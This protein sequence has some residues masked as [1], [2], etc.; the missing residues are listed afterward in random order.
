MIDMQQ[1]R[2]IR[3]VKISR[4]GIKEYKCPITI[5]DKNN[6][7]QG[8]IADINLYVSLEAEKRGI[9]MSRLIEVINTLRGKVTLNSVEEMLLEV[10][11]RLESK[12]S[13]IELSFP[14]FIEKKAP[15]SGLFGVVDYYCEIL[16]ES[17]EDDKSDITLTVHVPITSV[18]PCSKAISDNGA[19]NQRGTV[20]I[21]VKFKNEIFIEDIIKVAEESGSCDVYSL[22]KRTDEKYVTET[23]FENTKFVEDIVR[24]TAL[25]LEKDP[26]I[27]WFSVSVE[28]YESIHNHNAYAALSR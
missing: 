4:V 9:H 26:N 15:V 16:G 17:L 12:S 23:S 28:N 22:I 25:L 11:E 18:C 27:T 3:G 5:Y 8:T 19:H 7:E 14:Y 6:R 24:D 21:S 13:C 2:D 10:K 1:E 20:C